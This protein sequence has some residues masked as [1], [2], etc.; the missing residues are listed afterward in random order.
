[1]G[2][3]KKGFKKRKEIKNKKKKQK[4]EFCTQLPPTVFLDAPLRQKAPAAE[5]EEEEARQDE[6]ANDEAHGDGHRLPVKT[7]PPRVCVL[8]RWFEGLKV[9]SLRILL[10][11]FFDSRHHKEWRLLTA[12]SQ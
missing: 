4:S 10:I 7:S 1:M 3:R 5:T 11:K 6:E 8:W 2:K 9:G 12:H